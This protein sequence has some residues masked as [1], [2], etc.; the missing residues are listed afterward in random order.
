MLKSVLVIILGLASTVVLALASYHSK[1][2]VVR[3]LFWTALLAA[4]GV[5]VYSGIENIRSDH[6]LGLLKREAGTIRRFD[7][8]AVV[9]LAADWKSTTPPD[10]SRYL[11][12][13]E[14]GVNIRVELKTESAE[15]RWVE[16]TDSSPP[17][18][19]VGE[20]NSWVLDYTSQASAGS[21]ILGANRDDLQT[22]GTVV[23]RLYGVDHNATQ[24]GV[25]TVNRLTLN[26]F[27][28]GVAAYGC[29]YHPN[30]RVQL[31]QELGSPVRVE[32]YG[33]IAMQRLELR[34]QVP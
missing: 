3:A 17:K 24:D 4:A 22:C 1:S 8:A 27:V 11:R 18:I 29:E 30:L 21:W 14:R 26:F 9:T 5:I 16:F 13:G 6:E 31:T 23:M 20:N 2:E 33:P 28:N 34:I 19:V 12:T 7:V 32:L 25:V 10:F 15:M